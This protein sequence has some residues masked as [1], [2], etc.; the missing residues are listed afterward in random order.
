MINEQEH[1][2]DRAIAERM[3]AEACIGSSDKYHAGN[4]QHC[5]L[6]GIGKGSTIE[7]EGGFLSPN[8]A[9]WA[10]VYVQAGR[11]IPSRFALAFLEETRRT[12]NAEY[13][14]A[15]RKDVRY[16][17]VIINGYGDK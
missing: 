15:L 16:F 14:E 17:G 11:E 3:M 9:G 8:Y 12:D 4:C 6:R 2:K 1:K 13:A 7:T 5:S 10:R